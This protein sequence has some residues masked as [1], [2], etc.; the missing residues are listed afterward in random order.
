MCGAE[1]SGGGS[2]TSTA[3]WVN[4]G[5]ALQGPPERQ[6]GEKGRVKGGRH[7]QGHRVRDIVGF[8]RPMAG[9]PKMG[10]FGMK[11]ILS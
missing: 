3:G 5:Q 2:K 1:R 6:E 10:H 9:C 7:R 8:Q 4:L 11:A